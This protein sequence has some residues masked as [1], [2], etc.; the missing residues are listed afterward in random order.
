MSRASSRTRSPGAF[1]S[2]SIL[3]CKFGRLQM[4]ERALDQV[5][6][7]QVARV[8]DR[9]P[10]SEIG[11]FIDLIAQAPPGD[12]RPI[13]DL[14]RV[15]GTVALLGYR[16]AAPRR[17]ERQPVGDTDEAGLLLELADRSNRGVLAEVQ[18]A[19]RQRPLPYRRAA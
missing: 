2:I 18:A 6:D 10:G 15:K 14:D 8:H 17:H 12:R 16:V 13:H 19:S 4:R 1:T 7:R 5:D 3:E 9:H 11:R